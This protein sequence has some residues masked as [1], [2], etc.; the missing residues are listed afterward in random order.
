MNSSGRETVL[1]IIAIQLIST[2]MINVSV[3]LA[4][5]IENPMKLAVR[6]VLTILLWIGLYRG[7]AWVRLLELFLLILALGFAGFSLGVAMG[8]SHFPIPLMLF[9]WAQLFAFVLL[10]KG[11][12]VKEYFAKPK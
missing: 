12:G 2:V 6:E 10:L 7:L 1:I 8:T 4:V 11:P 5:G 3:W 9:F